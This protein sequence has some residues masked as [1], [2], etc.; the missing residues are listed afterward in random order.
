MT[1]DPLHS[2]YNPKTREIL[3]S[4]ECEYGS[5]IHECA[6]ALERK[7]KLYKNSEYLTMR[8]NGFEEISR[9]DILID[10]NTLNLTAGALDEASEDVQKS[11]G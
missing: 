4:P 6:H 8:N 5:V 11:S 3:L 2:G 9:A 1:D 10:E 7:L